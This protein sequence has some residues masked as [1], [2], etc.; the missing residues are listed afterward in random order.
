MIRRILRA[1]SSDL[2]FGSCHPLLIED[3]ELI[4]ALRGTG[5]VCGTVTCPAHIQSKDLPHYTL[6]SVSQFCFWGRGGA[7]KFIIN[8][9]CSIWLSCHI[10]RGWIPYALDINGYNVWVSCMKWRRLWVKLF[11][12]F[13]VLCSFLITHNMQYRITAGKGL[14]ICIASVTTARPKCHC[15]SVQKQLVTGEMERL[16]GLWNSER[17]EQGDPMH[18]LALI[19]PGARE[20]PVLPFEGQLF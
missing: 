5:P 12:S 15:V 8:R 1:D 13:L 19:I 11:T 2:R 20:I 18:H 17:Q 14:L 6:K 7:F 3:I 10:L 4:L 16:G 9:G